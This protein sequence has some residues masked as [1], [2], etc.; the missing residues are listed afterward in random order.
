MGSPDYR[1]FSVSGINNFTQKNGK[2][3][4]L[5]YGNINITG[6]YTLNANL[7]VPFHV[8]IS[9]GSK[10]NVNQLPVTKQLAMSLGADEE[11]ATSIA[12]SEQTISLNISGASDRSS[13]ATGGETGGGTAPSENEG[14]N[15]DAPA[16]P[17]GPGTGDN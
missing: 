5:G 10:S 13:P 4:G 8:N 1:G 9:A 15:N 2:F 3:I 7:L 14:E 12:A 6:A 17:A 16:A 11:L